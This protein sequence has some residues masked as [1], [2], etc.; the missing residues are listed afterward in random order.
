MALKKAARTVKPRAQRS[1]EISWARGKS[2]GAKASREF[3]SHTASSKQR[4][5]PRMERTKL[6]LSN[7][8]KRRERQA[9]S[10]ARTANSRVR[11]AERD[12]R[13]LATLA[14]VINNTNQIAPKR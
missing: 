1:R 8:A 2:V 13:R 7:C 11:A 12:T 4:A 5:P 3:S 6:S 10:A 14:Q 9:P